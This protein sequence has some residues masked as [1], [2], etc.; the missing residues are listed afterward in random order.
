MEKGKLPPPYSPVAP[1][2]IPG[3]GMQVAYQTQP[4]PMTTVYQPQPPQMQVMPAPQPVY[5][6]APGQPVIQMVQNPPP[7][8]VT[9]P[10]IHVVQGPP[11]AQAPAAPAPAQAVII[12]PHLTTAAGRMKCHYC[13]KEVVTEV[14]YVNGMLVW[15]LVG[16][17]GLLGIWPCCLIP[18]CVNGCKD[19]KHTCPNCKTIVSVY[20]RM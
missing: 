20:K 15:V 10:V 8:Q 2:N 19:V 6:P 14:K 16:T 4:A 11:P 3:P 18:F 13:Q 5:M 7:V 12:P 1:N 9:Q 17:L